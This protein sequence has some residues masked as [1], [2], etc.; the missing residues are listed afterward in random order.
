MEKAPDAFRTI[1]EVAEVLDTPA[2][3]LRFWESKFPQIRPVKRAGGRR[4]YRPG[5]VALLAGIRHLLHD[6]GLTI[7]GVQ[8][9]L[10]ESGVRHV[11]AMA[12]GL[13]QG[14]AEVGEVAEIEASLNLGFL[15]SVEP[16]A[17]IAREG[18]DIVALPA[19]K[20]APKAV[21][22]MRE[23]ASPPANASYYAEEVPEAPFIEAEEAEPAKADVLHLTSAGTPR[24]RAKAPEPDEDLPLLA[25]MAEWDKADEELAAEDMAAEDLAD[26]AAMDG[27][28]LSETLGETPDL[29]E[30]LIATEAEASDS[31]EPALSQDTPTLVQRLRALP[32]PVSAE[33][34]AA[35]APLLARA[36]EL[37]ARLTASLPGRD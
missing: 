13:A 28:P 14:F 31:S 8:K 2:H 21:E 23:A 15:D 9:V 4:Y 37:Q 33:A 20:R 17:I 19:R 12:R 18:A 22:R 29:S 16:E 3:V 36:L 7:R 34:A 24:R 5:D 10:R 27:V 35:L 32:R 11:Q 26:L 1:S 6:Q 30:D 25:R